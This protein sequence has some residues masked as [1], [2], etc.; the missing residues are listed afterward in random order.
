MADVLH[1]CTR[2]EQHAVVHFLWSKGLSTEEVHCEMCPMYGDN[3]FSW[4][5][6]FN[7]IQEFNKGRQSIGDRKR[8]GCPAEVSTEATVQRVE[9]IIHN[10]WRVSIND[11][12]CAVHMELRTSC[13]S[14]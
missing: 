12:A 9:Q 13:M 3:G 14:S 1:D 2:A 10:D 5:T 7:W 4:K 8:P 11:I 6:V